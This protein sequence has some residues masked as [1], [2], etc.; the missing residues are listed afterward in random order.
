MLL[1]GALCCN[2]PKLKQRF[3]FF[4]GEALVSC[5]SLLLLLFFLFAFMWLF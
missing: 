3:F 4:K 1:C 2:A 5:A